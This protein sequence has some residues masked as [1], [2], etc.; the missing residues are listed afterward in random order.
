[1]NPWM[2]WMACG[3]IGW[4]ALAPC[5]LAQQTPPAEV[6]QAAEQGLQP[7]LAQVPPTAVEEFGFA[8]DEAGGAVTLGAPFRVYAVAPEALARYQAGQ[9]AETLL[10]ATPLWYFPVLK[11]GRPQAILVVDRLDGRYQAVSLGYARLAAELGVVTRQWKAAEGYHPKL[12]IC[13]QARQHLFTVPEKGARNLTRL[14][15]D[16]PLPGAAA[17]AAAPAADYTELDGIDQ[18]VTQLKT[19]LSDTL[20]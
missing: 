8:A 3:M 9:A 14:V 10:T 1:M 4:M 20:P 16:A 11:G 17:Q 13:Y 5:V 6:Q 15:I 7:L 2:R 19:L 12:A 18:T